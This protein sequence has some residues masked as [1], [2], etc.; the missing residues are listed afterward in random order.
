M[1]AGAEL[2]PA[3]VWLTPEQFREI[4]RRAGLGPF[5]GR[6]RSE[7]LAGCAVGEPRRELLSR[8]HE[9]RDR[10]R[11]RLRAEIEADRKRRAKQATDGQHAEPG[12]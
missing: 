12:R 11:A 1:T 8:V 5:D 7:Y 2:L 4:N 10:E 3:R 6:A 9:I